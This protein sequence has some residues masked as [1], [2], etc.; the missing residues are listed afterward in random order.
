MNSDHI[1]FSEYIRNDPIMIEETNSFN[2]RIIRWDLIHVPD[3][4]QTICL[5]SKIPPTPIKDK[6]I[7]IIK[8]IFL[9]YI[10][11]AHTAQQLHPVVIQ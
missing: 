3:P 1:C 5:A 6:I 8:I 9:K 10:L 4:L 7:F 2:D 11:K